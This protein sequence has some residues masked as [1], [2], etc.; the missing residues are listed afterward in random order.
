MK[1]N[2]IAYEMSRL[3]TLHDDANNSNLFD[4]DY[5]LLI[6]SFPSYRP[7]RDLC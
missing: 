6:Q 1:D 7:A 2:A 4:V 3:W 5:K